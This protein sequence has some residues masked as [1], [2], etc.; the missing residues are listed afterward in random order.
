MITTI[1]ERRLVHLSTLAGARSITNL[2]WI[3]IRA[4]EELEITLPCGLN[5]FRGAF[6][7]GVTDFGIAIDGATSSRAGWD[8]GRDSVGEGAVSVACNEYVP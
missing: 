1:L 5:A 3:R 4:S 8:G 7:D 6:A 2:A